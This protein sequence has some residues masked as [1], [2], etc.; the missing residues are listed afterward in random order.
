MRDLALGAA[1]PIS[2]GK[3]R[4]ALHWDMICDLREDGEV[5][6]DGELVWKAGRF[7]HDPE[8][9]GDGA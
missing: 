9:V 6:A 3:N 8:P 7:L 5:Y 4:S 1:F 2:G